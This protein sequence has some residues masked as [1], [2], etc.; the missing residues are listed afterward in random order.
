MIETVLAV[1]MFDIVKHGKAGVYDEEGGRPSD[2][3]H[4]S[5]SET[6]PTSQKR[7]VGSLTSLVFLQLGLETSFQVPTTNFRVQRGVDLGI[8]TDLV[9]IPSS[10][11]ACGHN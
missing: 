3:A 11:I 6:M 2:D 10:C 4:I 1:R 8:T 7:D 9:G 5:E